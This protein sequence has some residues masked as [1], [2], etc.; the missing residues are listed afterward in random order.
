M[1]FAKFNMDAVAFTIGDR[2]VYHRDVQWCVVFLSDTTFMKLVEGFAYIKDHDMRMQVAD[3]IA[4]AFKPYGL[5]LMEVEY[6]FLMHK[7]MTILD[8]LL[9]NIDENFETMT[10]CY[11]TIAFSNAGFKKADQCKEREMREFVEAYGFG[12][13]TRSNREL[14]KGDENPRSE[15]HEIY[16]Y[17]AIK[18]DHAQLHEELA[19]YLFHPI[20]IQKWIDAGHKIDNYLS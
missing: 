6:W 10:S 3:Q 16:D 14:I 5:A 20:R 18:S 8:V 12:G 17:D 2:V 11:L 19:A 9:K 13:Y 15:N 1:T 7:P 4:Q